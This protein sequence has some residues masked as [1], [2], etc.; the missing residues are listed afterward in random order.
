[1]CL[2]DRVDYIIY[3]DLFGFILDVYRV[4]VFPSS[5][6]EFDRVF[7]DFGNTGFEWC[8]SQEP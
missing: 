1:M 8:G 2:G 7:E 4:F 3:R 6:G 5:E